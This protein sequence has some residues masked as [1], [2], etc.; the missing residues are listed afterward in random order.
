MLRLK[1]HFGI[2]R[3]KCFLIQIDGHSIRQVSWLNCGT[4]DVFSNLGGGGDR[5]SGTIS[6]T[7]HLFPSILASE[8][9]RY[10]WS[11]VHVD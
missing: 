10:K 3:S 11:S 9:Y 8:G 7:P 1:G 6:R 5:V 4:N 2:N